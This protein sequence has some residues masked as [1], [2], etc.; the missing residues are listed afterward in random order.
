MDTLYHEKTNWDEYASETAKLKRI[1]ANYA[2]DNMYGAWMRLLVNMQTVGKE[3]PGFTGTPAWACKNLNTAL[4]SWAELKHDAILYAEQPMGAE[5]GGGSDFPDPVKLNYVEPNVYFWQGL[6]ALLD[7]M[8]DVLK[9]VKIDDPDIIDKASTLRDMVQL[10]LEVAQD[11]L[12][13]RNTAAEKHQTLSY[14][15]SHMEW[16]TLSILDPEQDVATW[17]DVKGAE[18]S[19]ALVADVYTRNIEGCEKDGILFE[20]TGNANTIY[21]LVRMNGEIYLTRGATFS[22]YEFVRPLGDRLTD[23]QWQEM[24]EKGDAPAVPEWMAPWIMGQ[25]AKV[26]DRYIYSTGC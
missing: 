15:G 1:F 11:E 6:V 22:Y 8:T 26:G 24:L 10:C 21:V 18:R 2:D 25:P 13:G 7:K 12:A 23:E 16:F 20:A 4:A 9:E 3:A 19:V 14:L 5:C 17:S